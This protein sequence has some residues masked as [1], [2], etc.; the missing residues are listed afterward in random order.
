MLSSRYRHVLMLAN[1]KLEDNEENWHA[2]RMRYIVCFLLY[3]KLFHWNLMY[4]R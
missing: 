2:S 4:L 3:K 1:N